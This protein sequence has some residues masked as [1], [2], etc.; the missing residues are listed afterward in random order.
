M[1]KA[2]IAMSGGVDSSVAA[3]LMLQQGTDC[4]GSTMLLCGDLAPGG[5]AQDAATVAERLGISF[6]VFV[7]GA[8]LLRKLS[9]L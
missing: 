3:H 2:L 6:H 1:S 5:G 9:N 8:F 7:P 4:I